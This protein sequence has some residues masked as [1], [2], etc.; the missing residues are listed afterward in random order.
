MYKKPKGPGSAGGSAQISNVHGVTLPKM[1]L[2]FPVTE[3]YIK[4]FVD[5]KKLEAP[6]EAL[7]KFL[8]FWKHWAQSVVKFSRSRKF[9]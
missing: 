7:P 6:P 2:N 4:H 9:S 8:I 3:I 1:L 5:P